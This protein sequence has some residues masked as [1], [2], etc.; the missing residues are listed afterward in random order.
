[1]RLDL[2]PEERKMFHICMAMS[3]MPLPPKHRFLASFLMVT[4]VCFWKLW[5][6]EAAPFSE[7][8]DLLMDWTEPVLA[9]IFKG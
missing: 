8:L 5:F 1:M 9:S 3:S 7:S 2:M 6:K 4:T